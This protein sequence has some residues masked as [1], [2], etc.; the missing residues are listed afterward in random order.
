MTVTGA[1][2]K[3][4]ADKLST[5]QKRAIQ[6][7]ALNQKTNDKWDR[8]GRVIWKSPTQTGHYV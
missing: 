3:A 6:T 5:R 4:L 7:N 2:L 8:L 1:D